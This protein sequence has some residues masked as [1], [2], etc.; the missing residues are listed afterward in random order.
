MR[1]PK[2]IKKMRTPRG[3]DELFEKE[4]PRHDTYKEAFKSLNKEFTQWFDE[5]RYSNYESYRKAR[6]ARIK[7]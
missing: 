7:G 1:I 3:F 2:R 6:E 5:P 4:I